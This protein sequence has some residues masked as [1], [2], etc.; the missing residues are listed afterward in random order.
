MLVAA[1]DE[2]FSSTNV[3]NYRKLQKNIQDMSGITRSTDNKVIASFTIV[4]KQGFPTWYED[5]FIDRNLASEESLTIVAREGLN[6]FGA[7]CHV[8]RTCFLLSSKQA[9]RRTSSGS[10]GSNEPSS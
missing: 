1:F 8:G 5:T 9:L 6:K 2:T 4:K 3:E 7:S 10:I